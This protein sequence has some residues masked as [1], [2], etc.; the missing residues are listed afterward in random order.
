MRPAW[1][2]HAARSVTIRIMFDW[3]GWSKKVR[4]GKMNVGGSVTCS[5]GRGLRTTL[6]RN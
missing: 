4:R 5:L 2:L 6:G 3:P 1:L